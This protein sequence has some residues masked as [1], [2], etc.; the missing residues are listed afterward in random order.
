MRV[1][2]RLVFLIVLEGSTF[3]YNNPLFSINIYLPYRNSLPSS[4]TIGGLCHSE[5]SGGSTSSSLRPEERFLAAPRCRGRLK[6][7][8]CH[9]PPDEVTR[10]T[11]DRVS[12]FHDPG[13]GWRNIRDTRTRRNAPSVFFSFLRCRTSAP[14]FFF[15]FFLWL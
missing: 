10:R 4:F 3:A 8:Q 2:R 12:Y 15:F 5:N 6:L 11:N 7:F 1:L 13:A 9:V 14:S